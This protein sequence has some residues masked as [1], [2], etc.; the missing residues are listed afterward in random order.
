MRGIYGTVRA[1][2]I[3]PKLDVDI[4]YYYRPTRSTTSDEFPTFMS[5]DTSCLVK[6]EDEGGTIL[7]LFNFCSE[8]CINSPIVV[9][10]PRINSTSSFVFH[11][12]SE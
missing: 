12:S 6:S 4:L 7:G 10:S 8:I 3:D 9:S 11:L 1:A 2:N 5:L